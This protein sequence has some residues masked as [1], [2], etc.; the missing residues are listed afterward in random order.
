MK[1]KKWLEKRPEM[2]FPEWYLSNY[3]AYYKW[4]THQI[5]IDSKK[6]LLKSD[7]I[8][9]KDIIYRP[10]SGGEITKRLVY[11][12]ERKITK[13]QIWLTAS[14]S[15]VGHLFTY[16]PPYHWRS[17]RFPNLF[18]IELDKEHHMEQLA[19]KQLRVFKKKLPQDVLNY[20][21]LFAR[22]TLQSD[23]RKIVY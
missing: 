6:I 17:E 18:S 9:V 8:R 13:K 7:K 12:K 19:L 3:I 23:I 22:D 20:I 14:N 10:S 4:C 15:R 11:G 2:I 21:L 1:Y 5:F 16:D